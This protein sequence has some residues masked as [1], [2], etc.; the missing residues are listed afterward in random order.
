MKT[1]A[2]SFRSMSK[3]TSA[4]CPV[5]MSTAALLL[6]LTSLLING[7]GRSANEGATEHLWQLL[8][9]GQVPFVGYFVF[10]WL[11]KAPKSGLGVLGIQSAALLAACAP[12]F[13]YN[14]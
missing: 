6:V 12:V 4:Y 13:A 1:S 9:A 7:T 11:S 14:L 3:K 5:L 8:V 2:E 10:H